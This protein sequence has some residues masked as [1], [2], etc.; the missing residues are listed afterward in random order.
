MNSEEPLHDWLAQLDEITMEA[1]TQFGTLTLEALHWKPN[2]NMWSIAENLAH[3]M[4]LNTSYYPV[5][6]KARDNQLK[7]PWFAGIG[8]IVKTLGKVLLQ[9]VQPDRKRKIKTFQLWEPVMPN[10]PNDVLA[11]FKEH[12]KKLAGELRLCQSLIGKG[13]VIH[14]P[15]NAKIVYSFEDAVSL[16]I[17]HERRH[18]VQAR[19]VLDLVL[20]RTQ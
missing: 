20:S 12:Q 19:E 1:A 8:F 16:I 6:Q 2:P 17:A 13:V 11:Q 14:S 7:L 18:L 5:W 4:A 15:A 9:S 10:A 3:L